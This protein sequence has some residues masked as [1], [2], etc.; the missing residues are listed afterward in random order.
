METP[1]FLMCEPTYFAVNYVINPWMAAH[2]NNIDHSRAL[3]QWQD[4]YQ[5]LTQYV[6]VHLVEPQP[7]L[8]D[9]V[10]TANAALIKNKRCVLSHFRHPER[11]LEEPFYKQWFAA[12]DYE[13]IEIP[14]QIYFEG[15]GDALFQ[16]DGE[17]LWMGYGIRSDKKASEH[18]TAFFHIPVA[19][20]KLIDEK[21]Y[22]L[23][24]CFFPLRHGYVMYYPAAFDR[25]ANQLIEQQVPKEK[26]I[27][28]SEEDAHH[29][30]C[31]AVLI[32]KQNHFGIIIMNYASNSLQRELTELGYELII[33]PVDEFM[34]AGGANKCLTLII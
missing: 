28:V 32:P 22:H 23:D 12:H 33:Q 2:V 6:T 11:Q 9:F 17:L 14:D 13:A 24:T 25:E 31:N 16:P 27:L 5:C 10:F 20:L 21:F 18:L 34:K 26:R 29:F 1:S 19:T 30:A 15:E 3:Q 7:Q 8:P 4:F